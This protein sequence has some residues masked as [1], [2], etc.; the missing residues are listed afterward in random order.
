MANLTVSTDIDSFMQSANKAAARTSLGT[1]ASATTISAGTGLTGGGD[2]SANRTLS[3]DFSVVA[4]TA[5]IAAITPA[6]IGAASTADIV[7]LIT[8]ADAQ[9]L[10]T[11]GISAI[12]PE[13]IGAISTTQASGF[14]TTQQ[15][16]AFITSAQLPAA[17]TAQLG[18]IIVGDN[19]LI[20]ESG[21]LSSTGGNSSANPWPWDF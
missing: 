12:T 18:A 11:A 16:S 4:S 9:A 19:L 6:S 13:S 1:P 8:S 3:V 2:L 7:G 15:I 14:A 21:V 5:S 17:T 20:D 10:V